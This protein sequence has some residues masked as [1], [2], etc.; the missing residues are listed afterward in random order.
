[1]EQPVSYHV[2]AAQVA[3]TSSRWTLGPIIREYLDRVSTLYEDFLTSSLSQ[4]IEVDKGIDLRHILL[5]HALMI[6][7]SSCISFFFP[8][9]SLSASLAYKDVF[10]TEKSE[11]KIKELCNELRKVKRELA[12]RAKREKRLAA[13][14]KDSK[15]LRKVLELEVKEFAAKI[16]ELQVGLERTRSE[17]DDSQGLLE[18]QRVYMVK[19]GREFAQKNKSLESEK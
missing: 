17:L 3:P 19:K 10:E 8:L 6:S 18:R 7:T 11:A 9:R 12:V 13:K 14:V 4:Y 16:S 5:R 2:V 15:A 1:M